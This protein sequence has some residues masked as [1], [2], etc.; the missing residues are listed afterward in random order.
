MCM[1]PEVIIPP[2]P[3][4]KSRIHPHISR[5]C[6]MLTW[7]IRHFLKNS[8]KMSFGVTATKSL[9]VT[10]PSTADLWMQ[11]QTP[12]SKERDWGIFEKF[13][14]HWLSQWERRGLETSRKELRDRHAVTKPYP[15][16]GVDWLKSPRSP[17]RNVKGKRWWFAS[18]INRLRAN[19]G[20]AWQDLLFETA[21]GVL[22]YWYYPV[23]DVKSGCDS[24]GSEGIW[25]TCCC[26][27]STS[28]RHKVAGV[29]Q[30]PYTD[31]DDGTW[32]HPDHQW[33]LAV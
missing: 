9:S 6:H 24:V 30:S 1:Y 16:F 2:P 12:T 19:M 25:S 28:V 32:H 15:E 17:A 31:S 10:T 4:W 5:N 29:S 23:V 14:D 22:G 13:R 27:G 20:V 18:R 33:H 11:A 26:G 3:F 8:S 21:A 7:I